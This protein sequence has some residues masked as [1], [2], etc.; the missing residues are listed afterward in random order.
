[1]NAT[2]DHSPVLH[3]ERVNLDEFSNLTTYLFNTNASKIIM[4]ADN[5]K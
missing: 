1:L 3:R 5:Y 4:F 2:G